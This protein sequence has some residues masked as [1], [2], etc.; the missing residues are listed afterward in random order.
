ARID[1]LIALKR[2]MV[3]LLAERAEAQF[4]HCVYDLWSE[5]KRVALKRVARKVLQDPLPNDEILT[6][7]RDGEVTARSVRRSDGYTLAD[8]ESRYQH[9]GAGDFVFHGLDGFAGAAGV[10]TMPGKCS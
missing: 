8:D 9:A 5:Q 7:Y 1:E 2:R 10:A 4:L 3:A 6:A